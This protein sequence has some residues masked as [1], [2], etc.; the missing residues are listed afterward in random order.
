MIIV[1]YVI[2][3]FY[4][5]L[6]YSPYVD[7]CGNMIY[8]SNVM[9]AEV[10]TNCFGG[11]FALIMGF[12]LYSPALAYLSVPEK[13]RKASFVISSLR[14]TCIKTIAIMISI[15]W[16]I[17]ILGVVVNTIFLCLAPA[18]ILISVFRSSMGY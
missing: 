17:A 18:M 10:A 9:S 6:I 5:K 15:N 2:S 3:L 4:L 16:I 12:A 8:F 11:I 1:G 13:V 14:G 7:S